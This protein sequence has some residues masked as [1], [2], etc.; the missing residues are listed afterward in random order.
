MKT[1]RPTV[2]RKATSRSRAEGL[3]AASTELVATLAAGEVEAAS[4]RQTE[5]RPTLRTLD[6]VAAEQGGL[7][8]VRL[9]LLLSDFELMAGQTL[10]LRRPR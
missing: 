2:C 8:V 7:V 4:F 10:V 5:D 6:A 1:F 9:V 3:A